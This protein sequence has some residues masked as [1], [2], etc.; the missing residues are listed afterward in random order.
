M[1]N[2]KKEFTCIVCPRGCHITVHEDG[3]VTGNTCIRG[4]KYVLQE[5]THPTRMITS[6]VYV[7]GGEINR[8]SVA[9]S[10]PIPKEKIF[11]VMDEIHK[12]S[13]KAPV[14]IGD[15]VIENVLGTGSNIVI[16]KDVDVK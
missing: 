13:V 2:E 15:I 11:E 10:A 8:A 7:E 6:S 12:V 4:K 1:L 14:H 3:S 9:T 16:T 5:M